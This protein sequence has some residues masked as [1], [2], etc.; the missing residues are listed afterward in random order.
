MAGKLEGKNVAI[1]V[2]DGFEEV[3]LFSPKEA[4][5]REGATCTIVSP[6]E[7]RVKGWNHVA[8]G[9]DIAVD[10]PLAQARVDDFDAL[11]LPGGVMNPDK[12]R[13]LPEVRAFVRDF[14]ASGRPVAAICHAP[15]TLIDAGVV[16]GRRL[17]SWPSLRTD[18]EN[19]GA[20]WVD[21]P[22]V[23]EDALV[24][25]RKPADLDAFNEATCAEFALGR[26]TEARRA[27][28][29]ARVSGPSPTGAR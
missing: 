28:I 18:L 29:V 6:K 8:W 24:T 22:V 26:R 13:V 25:S 21:E 20:E 3:E 1:L 15:W 2:A 9:R 27:R 14:F 16:E 17:T 10:R 7:G 5:E 23:V 12:L 11:L 4:L 19:A